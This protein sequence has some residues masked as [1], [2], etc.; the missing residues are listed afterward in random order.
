MPEQLSLSHFTIKGLLINIK[1][2]ESQS[3]HPTA[4][5]SVSYSLVAP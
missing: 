1:F 5:F 3:F 2:R 4:G